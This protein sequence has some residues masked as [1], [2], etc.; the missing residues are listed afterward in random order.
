[1]SACSHSSPLWLTLTVFTWGEYDS[2]HFT[3]T[4]E[5]RLCR[6]YALGVELFQGSLWESWNVFV[7]ELA[8]LFKAFAISSALESIA[9]RA[10]TLMPILLLQVESQRSHHMPGKAIEHLVTGRPE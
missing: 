3:D 9:L 4:L 7:S 5:W 6:S 1:M 10:A 8:R 2:E